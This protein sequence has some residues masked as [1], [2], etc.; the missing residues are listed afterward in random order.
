[1]SEDL[2]FEIIAE[3]VETEAQL[4]RLRDLGIRNAQGFLLGAPAPLSEPRSR[5]AAQQKSAKLRPRD[6][7]SR[8]LRI[9]APEPPA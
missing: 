2:G 6:T 8:P 9:D 7:K 1:M 3:G 4:E 5:P